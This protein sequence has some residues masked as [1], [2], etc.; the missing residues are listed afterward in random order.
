MTTHGEHAESYKPVLAIFNSTHIML[1][2]FTSPHLVEPLTPPLCFCDF[3]STTSFVSYG[4]I[5][6]YHH[7]EATVICYPM[8]TKPLQ[9]RVGVVKN[10]LARRSYSKMESR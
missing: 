4:A 6:L 2:P 9:L 1:E 8:F 10:H 3:S 7:D 5:L